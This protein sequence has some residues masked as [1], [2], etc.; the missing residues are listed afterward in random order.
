M[1]SSYRVRTQVGVDKSVQVDLQQDFETLEILSL[2][3]YQRDIYTRVCSDYGVICGRVFANNGFG[4]PNVK[5]SLFIPLSDE[6]SRNPEIANIYPFS[7]I[8]NLDVNGYRYNLLPK[9]ESHSGHVPTGSFPTREEILKEKNYSEVYDK[10]YKF[11]VKTN[12][13][14]DYMIFGVPVGSFTIFLDSPE[15]DIKK[16]QK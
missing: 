15:E 13:S 3:L 6:D 10:Y 7:N 1:N 8:S 9:E 4:V 2:K 14:G 11:T 12:D 16:R 5:I